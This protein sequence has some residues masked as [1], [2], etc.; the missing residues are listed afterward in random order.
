MSWGGMRS[1][2]YKRIIST[3]LNEITLARATTI[4]KA[5]GSEYLVVIM[6]MFMQH[7]VMLS[8]NLLYK[9]LTRAKK[10]AI[11]VEESKAIALAVKQVSDRNRY[12]YLA[13]RLSK[14]AKPE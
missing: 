7:F 3:G 2:S 8:R 1:T 6:P 5:Q 10:L 14:L 9:G 12:T 11:I 13:H 4:H